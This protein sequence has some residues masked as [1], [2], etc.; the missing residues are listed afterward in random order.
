LAPVRPQLVRQPVVGEPE[1]IEIRAGARPV[2]IDTAPGSDRAVLAPRV[3]RFR[4]LRDPDGLA[5][6][7]A[8]AAAVAIG[9]LER[10][11]PGPGRKCPI[12]AQ[13]DY[14]ACRALWQQVI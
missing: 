12:R 5:A 14:P 7:R 11:P 2:P 9:H 1:A 8:A 10:L 6:H 3:R 13:R 4:E